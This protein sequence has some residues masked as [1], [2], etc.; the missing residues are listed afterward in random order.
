M[1]RTC[2]SDGCPCARKVAVICVMVAGLWLAPAASLQAAQ[3]SPGALGGTVTGVSPEGQHYAI[4]AARL[5][6]DGSAS[7]L[8]SLAGF[9]GADGQYKFSSV[10]PGKYTLKVTAPGYEQVTKE[11]TVPPGSAVTQDVRMKLAEVHQEI[12]VRERAPQISQQSAAPPAIISAPSL[13]TVPTTQTR[14]K[15]ALPFVPSVVRTND[16]KIYIKGSEETQGMLLTNDLESVD[17]VTG[18]FIIDV[19]VDAIESLEVFK[20]PFLTEYGGFSG[21]MTS[22]HTKPPS[23]SWKL[24]M[25]DL[26]P[27]IRGKAGH[28]VGFSKAVPRLYFSG[29][30]TKKLTF[31][32]AFVYEMVKKPIRGLA[33]PHDEAKTQGYTSLS[34][35]Q[36]MFSPSHLTVVRVNLFPRRQQFANIRALLPQPASSD[37]GQ[38]GYSIEASDSYQLSSGGLLASRFKFTRVTSY[39]HGQG[40]ADMLLTPDGLAGNYFNAWSRDAHQEEGLET[41][42]FPMKEWLGKHSLMVGGGFLHRGFDGVSNSH[43][44]L[45]L[46][47]DG[48][49]EERIDFSGAGRLSVSDMQAS[50]FVQDH[51][52]IADRFAL[53]LGV[54][55]LGESLGD[56]ANF[57]PR[58]G[59]VFSPDRNGKTIFRGGIGIFDD[60]VPLLAGDFSDNPQRVVSPLDSQGALG[61]P[62]TFTNACA[63]LGAG[64]LKLPTPCS[65]LGSNPYNLTWRVEADRQLGSKLKLRL[66]F[67]KSRTFNEFVI[68]PQLGPA[69][70]LLVLS[71]SGS[72]R[73]HEYEASV[74]Y[75]PGEGSDLSVTYVHSRSHG[76]LNT[77]NEIFVPFEQP[78]I[79]PNVSAFLPS[80]VPD[81]LIALGKFK[82]PMDFMIIP[83]FD[84]HSGFPYSVV[85]VL[86]EYQGAPNSHRYPIYFSVDWRVYRDF[87]L[88]FGIHKGHKFRLGVYSVN[89]T[90]RQN[91]NDVYNNIASPMFGTFAGLGKRINGIVI[92]FAE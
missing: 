16:K 90:G 59:F 61:S 24:S 42:Q 15:E 29:P 91:P 70:P 92:G 64:G 6:L 55:Y 67:L 12:E 11:V 28:W 19:P 66:S 54:R 38:K 88:P 63:R 13:K 32:E 83:A 49:A 41:F 79:R 50:G 80:D 22:I 35:F 43:P 40:S 87:P 89:T 72:S 78:V 37:L 1:P 31:S 33:W 30:I 51:W 47:E 46:R 21:G 77:I 65:D 57:A 5:E 10:T 84:L 17:P 62:R 60:R 25:N 85:D 8:P 44:V 81:R 4:E 23:S 7:G 45:L 71:D 20:A 56:K 27:S 68:D 36:Y 48:T 76:D 75:Q 58:L 52:A 74:Q 9:S 82:L 14:F 26:N 34:T 69:N 2:G 73:Y 86:D 53:D 18:S 3:S 39:S